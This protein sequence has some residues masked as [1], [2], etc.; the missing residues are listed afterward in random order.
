MH[1]RHTNEKSTDFSV[2]FVLF[3]LFFSLVPFEL[4][5]NVV[6]AQS[7]FS[8]KKGKKCYKRHG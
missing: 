7:R 6:N 5:V 8:E 1:I 4:I 2:F 3:S